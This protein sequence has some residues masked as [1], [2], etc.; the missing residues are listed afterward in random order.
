MMA[1]NHPQALDI[2]FESPQDRTYVALDLETTGLNPD[3]DSIIEIGAVKFQGHDVLD[4]FQTLV[5]PFRELPQ[6]IQRLTGI[7][8]RNVGPSAGLCCRSRGP[9]GFHRHPPYSG[10]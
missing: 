2:P 5:N 4:V 10:A 6:F 8:Q 7:A 1:Q 9:G 3:Q